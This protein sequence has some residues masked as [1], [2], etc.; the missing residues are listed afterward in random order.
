MAFQVIKMIDNNKLAQ[1]VRQK[2]KAEI[3]AA[4]D[5]LKQP[6]KTELDK[7][8]RRAWHRE[9]AVSKWPEWRQE[10]YREWRRKQKQLNH[11]KLLTAEE[12]EWQR[13]KEEKHR[14]V[15]WT[16]RATKGLS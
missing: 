16:N 12:E 10:C 1:M 13:I 7:W 5:A 9:E 14:R 15:A 3:D 4:I 2:W 11:P 6:K 8:F